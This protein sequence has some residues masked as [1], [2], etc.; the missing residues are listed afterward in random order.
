MP[1]QTVNMPSV[2]RILFEKGFPWPAAWL[3]E[4]AYWRKR[5][6][7]VITSA[8]RLSWGWL[9][10]YGKVVYDNRPYGPWECCH[11]IPQSQFRLPTS[12]PWHT[13]DC[14]DYLQ[15]RPNKD[16]AWRYVTAKR[17]KHARVTGSDSTP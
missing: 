6:R 13:F 15:P 11:C 16:L 2:S 3:I 7:E 12:F 17:A 4:E 5:F 14:R 9:R 10:G 1:A 8:S